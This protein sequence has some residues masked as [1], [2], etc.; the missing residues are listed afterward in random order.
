MATYYATKDLN[1]DGYP[2]KAGEKIGTGEVRDAVGDGEFTPVDKF[3]RIGIGHIQ[4][5]RNAGLVI[6]KSPAPAAKPSKPSKTAKPCYT[7]GDDS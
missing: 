1:I 6:D 5:H 3:P 4:A 7:D 2:I